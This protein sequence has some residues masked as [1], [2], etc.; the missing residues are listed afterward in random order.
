MKHISLIS[1]EVNPAE[2]LQNLLMKNP[3]VYFIIGVVEDRDSN[4]VPYA[5]KWKCTN[6]PKKIG[7]NPLK[8]FRWATE[9][10]QGTWQRGGFWS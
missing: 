8:V 10:Q 3:P 2:V 1:K 6:V 4:F 9:R 7:S 5:Q